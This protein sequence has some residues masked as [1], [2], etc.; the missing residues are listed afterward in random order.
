M[1]VKLVLHS[2][3]FEIKPITIQ[4]NVIRS[5]NVNAFYNYEYIN[6]LSSRKKENCKIIYAVVRREC[7]SGNEKDKTEYRQILMIAEL[8]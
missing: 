7:T 5:P 3:A 8:V 2:G 6:Y 1:S 4:A